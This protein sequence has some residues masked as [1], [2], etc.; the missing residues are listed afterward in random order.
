MFINRF[1]IVIKDDLVETSFKLKDEYYESGKDLVFKNDVLEKIA[2]ETRRSKWVLNLLDEH[3]LLLMGQ[4][5]KVAVEAGGLKMVDTRST[6]HQNCNW[7]TLKIISNEYC[8][9][10]RYYYSV[11]KND[12]SFSYT[13]LFENSNI[14]LDGDLQF[15]FNYRSRAFVMMTMDSF[16][17]IPYSITEER[18][19]ESFIRLTP[20]SSFP[21]VSQKN[22]L[23][24]TLKS[25]L[26]KKA[27][28][29]KTVYLL[30]AF[31]AVILMVVILVLFYKREKMVSQMVVSNTD[32]RYT[33]RDSKGKPEI[34][35]PKKDIEL[36]ARYR[37]LFKGF[38]L[39]SR[40]FSFFKGLGSKGSRTNGS[41]TS[42]VSAYGG[43]STNVGKVNKLEKNYEQSEILGGSKTDGKVNSSAVDKYPTSKSEKPSNVSKKY[44]KYVDKNSKKEKSNSR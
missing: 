32:L 9:T 26:E 21:I 16:Y 15:I 8:F 1:Y 28:D 4:L 10:P 5:F 30:S 24:D 13:Q 20:T 42:T 35:L 43:V 34:G 6:I 19:N 40:S 22:H 7:Q 33:S 3:Y 31:F 18:K 11:L 23:F 38:D 29:Y 39:I 41:N 36:K 44:K 12:F 37:Q 25:E 2:F 27:E 17:V 14:K